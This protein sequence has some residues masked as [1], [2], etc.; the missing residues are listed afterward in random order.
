MWEAI[1]E[2][3]NIG[4]PVGI[5]RYSTFN[6]VALKNSTSAVGYAMFSQS[7]I[8]VVPREGWILFTVLFC[9]LYLI[10]CHLKKTRIQN[11]HIV[12]F[13]GTWRIFF[14]WKIACKPCFFEKFGFCVLVWTKLKEPEW[15]VVSINLGAGSLL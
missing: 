14:S 13:C 11:I 5:S 9:V 1:I 15:S 10:S 2:K 6:T 4:V 7:I 3:K 12:D 8:V